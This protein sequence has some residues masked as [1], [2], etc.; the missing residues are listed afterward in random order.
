[1][2]FPTVAELEKYYTRQ[3]RGRGLEDDLPFYSSS[4][5]RQRGGGLGSLFGALAKRLIPFAK[6]ILWPAAK[7]YVLPHAT[8]AALALTDDILEGK[9]VGSSIKERGV[10]AI[11]G[12]T[13]QYRE[14][15]G[16]G[17]Q[18]RS[19]SRKRAPKRKAVQALN[20]C[21]AKWPKNL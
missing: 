3:Q 8:S 14:Q 9:N 12:A 5:K 2:D 4:Y 17:R 1:M 10:E 16:S 15:S 7:K 18:R 19:I 11:K 6:N 13:Q 21:K 20:I